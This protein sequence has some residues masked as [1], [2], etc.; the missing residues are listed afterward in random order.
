MQLNFVTLHNLEGLC[1]A[2]C[3]GRCGESERERDSGSLSGPRDESAGSHGGATERA[4][5]PG[6]HGNQRLFSTL[7]SFTLYFGYLGWLN[8]SLLIW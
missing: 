1:S 4:A 3:R 6:N 5:Q 2:D 7:D 8:M